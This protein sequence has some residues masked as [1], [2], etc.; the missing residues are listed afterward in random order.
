MNFLEVGIKKYMVQWFVWR[1]IIWEAEEWETETGRL[2]H[3]W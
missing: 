2:G 3:L 1:E